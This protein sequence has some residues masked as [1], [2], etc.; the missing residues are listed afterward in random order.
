MPKVAKTKACKLKDIVQKFP[1][2]FTIT[3]ANTL[4][5]KIC[6]TT[7]KHEKLFFVESHK[8]STKHTAG[9]ASTH[10]PQQTFLP[11][12]TSADFMEDLV[13]AFIK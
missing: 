4:F 12:A 6:E 2:E 5:C 13:T 8:N 10:K 9:L 1:D 7:A 3:P 11:N